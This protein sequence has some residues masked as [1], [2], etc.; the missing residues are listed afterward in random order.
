MKRAWSRIRKQ[1]ETADRDGLE[2]LRQPATDQAIDD[3]QLR[4]GCE[5]PDDYL[6]S[7]RVHDGQDDESLFDGWRLLSLAEVGD[8]AATLGHLLDSGEFEGYETDHDSKVRDAWWHRAWIPVFGNGFGDFVCIDL[9][10]AGRGR[11]GQL[12][13]FGHD[14]A[15]R[16]VLASSFKAWMQKIAREM[17]K[18]EAAPRAEPVV[19]TL[20]GVQHLVRN[21]KMAQKHAVQGRW[22]LALAALTRFREHGDVRAA[23]SLVYLYAYSGEWDRV[24]DVAGSAITATDAFPHNNVPMEIAALVSRAGQETGDWDAA[25]RIAKETPVVYGNAL[26]TRAVEQEQDVFTQLLEEAPRKSQQECARDWADYERKGVP[27]TY[28]QTDE[29]RKRHR[30]MMAAEYEQREVAVALMRDHPD[31]CMFRDAV[32]LANWFEPDDAW[33]EIATRLHSWIPVYYEQVAPAVLLTS[34]ATRALMTPSRCREVLETP[35]VRWWWD[36]QKS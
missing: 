3:A 26:L 8:N 33:R 12:V 34:S 2:S 5:L 18:Q 9:A 16:I 30:F 35:R 15:E 32:G 27:S 31:S 6:E 22:Q 23:A 29:R 36:Y 7:L 24:L 11:G 1:L 19:V 13:L 21:T 14:D 10:P 20:E 28:S 4:L 25:G 17:A